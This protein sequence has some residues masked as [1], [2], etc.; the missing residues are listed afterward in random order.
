MGARSSNGA[1]LAEVGGRA[2]GSEKEN[3]MMVFRKKVRPEVERQLLI[4]ELRRLRLQGMNLDRQEVI[5]AEL[6]RDW[7]FGWP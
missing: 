4:I 2:P 3:W 6:R 1:H 7:E 5:V